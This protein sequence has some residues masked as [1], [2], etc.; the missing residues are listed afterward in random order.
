MLVLFLIWCR[1]ELCNWLPV[2]KGGHMFE[3]AAHLGEKLGLG[4]R[5][6]VE[7]WQTAVSP[8]L[9]QCLMF[10]S[11]HVSSSEVTPPG[12]SL[13]SCLFLSLDTAAC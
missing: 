1:H 3:A 11:Q 6:I 12:A 8:G 5:S 7:L 9:M 13:Q 10:H 2:I 4:S